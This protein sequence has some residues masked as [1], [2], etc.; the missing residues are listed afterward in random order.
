M[1]GFPNFSL[2]LKNLILKTYP[3]IN[4]IISRNNGYGAGHNIAIF[5]T[6]REKI[7]YHLILNPDIYFD[8]ISI[9]S[10]FGFMDKNLNIGLIMPKILYP[11]GKIQFLCKLLPTPYD[12]I[13]RRFAPFKKKVGK[14][15]EKYE[16]RFT[17]YSKKMEVPSLSGCF[18][19]IR[20]SVLKQIGGFDE[21]YFMYAEDVDLCRR[22]GQI[23]KAV[24]YPDVEVTHNYE[25]GSYKNPKLLMH[26]IFSAIKYF[27]KWGWFFDKERKSINKETLEKLGYSQNRKRIRD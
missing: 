24:Y 19:F 22:I 5:K 23:S 6:I 11:N 2:K 17:N 10:I 9:E 26:H 15:N 21:R 14:R 12:L 16:L 25:K 7:K 8:P 4:Y 20:T 1:Y 13:F 3:G 27:N 18:M